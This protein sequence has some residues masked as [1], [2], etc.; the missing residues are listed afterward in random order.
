MTG[1]G[2][3]TRYR[4]L[5]PKDQ[6]YRNHDAEGND[7]SP[8][9]F[10]AVE[11][12]CT[13]GTH[14]SP[15]GPPTMRKPL[16]FEGRPESDTF[17]S[18]GDDER[19]G[20]MRRSDMNAR[21]ESADYPL[22]GANSK[23]DG[24]S[25]HRSDYLQ[26]ELEKRAAQPPPTL[27]KP[28]P[29]TGTTEAKSLHREFSPDE[30]RDAVRKICPL[31]G[32]G[33]FWDGKQGQWVSTQRAD[34][35]QKELERRTAGEVPKMRKPLPFNGESLA[36]ADFRPFPGDHRRNQC[37]SAKFPS[38]DN[39]LHGGGAKGDFLSSHKA[40]YVHEECP[41]GALLRGYPPEKRVLEE[42]RNYMYWNP[43]KKEW[44]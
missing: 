25:T 44:F 17:R 22:T 1:T 15:R 34:F 14:R 6:Y 26:W 39:P 21:Q 11:E 38:S 33:G 18:F 31:S 32:G 13:C 9:E 24:A 8:E 23:L 40:D 12:L 19:R 20:A 42:G 29:F 27:R 7:V 36:Q 43:A 35:D 41:A 5:S 30:A 37:D 4:S 28:L 16:P 2:G 10:Q 3:L